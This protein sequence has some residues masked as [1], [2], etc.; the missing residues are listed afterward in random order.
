V[1]SL[2]GVAEQVRA[3]LEIVRPARI[4]EIG[5]ESGGMTELLGAWAV[6]HDATLASID[7][8]PAPRL[9]RLEQESASI[10]LVAGVSPAALDGIDGDAWIIDG[11]H[12]YATVT[13][14]LRHV[15]SAGASPR[16]AV[17]HDVGWPCARRDAYY[18]PERIPTDERHPYALR[19]GVVP[20]DPGIVPA[21]FSGRGRFFWAEREGGPRNG[22]LT[23]IEDV[24]AELGGLRF[25]VMPCMFGV[26][27]LYSADASWA[28]ELAVH[29]APWSG[30]MLLDT[31]ERNRL[32]LYLRVLELQDAI[33]AAGAERDR[34]VAGLHDQIARAESEALARRVDAATQVESTI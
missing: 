33:E 1:H 15:F 19:G 24:I 18:A 21:G 16:L 23:A 20:G 10:Q 9:R 26:G 17:M 29:L 8:E 7:P 31:L 4:V 12:N 32:A 30:S 27:F 2:T 25:D 28:D 11:D 13:A 5:S 6:E 14:E 22:V 34:L 3:A